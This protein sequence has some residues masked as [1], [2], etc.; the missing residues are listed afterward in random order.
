[1]YR[2]F[3]RARKRFA[4]YSTE[5]ILQA[6]DDYGL[7]LDSLLGE[8]DTEIED[9]TGAPVS[10]I[11]AIQQKIYVKYGNKWD[12]VPPRGATTQ[13]VDPK[14]FGYSEVASTIP[15]LLDYLD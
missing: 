9:E 14:I 13:S 1:M 5:D 12:R 3:S 11:R 7:S 6:M 15:E 8:N 4:A 10:L 2:R